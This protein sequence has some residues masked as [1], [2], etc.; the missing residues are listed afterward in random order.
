M[1]PR[2]YGVSEYIENITGIDTKIK[3]DEEL[4][5]T[6]RNKPSVSLPNRD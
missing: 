4:F 1:Y 6:D 2:G 5:R 3:H